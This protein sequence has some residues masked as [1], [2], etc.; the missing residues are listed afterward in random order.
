MGGWDL[1]TLPLSL[2]EVLRYLETSC[3]VIS[4]VTA[5]TSSRPDRKCLRT[6]RSSLSECFRGSDDIT[7][8]FCCS[9][10]SHDSVLHHVFADPDQRPHPLLCV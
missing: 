8:S 2:Q 3:S 7:G 5:M 9:A 1:E 10:P 4:D 6:D